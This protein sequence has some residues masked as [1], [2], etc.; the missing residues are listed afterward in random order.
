MD[1]L[2]DL[3][4]TAPASPRVNQPTPKAQRPKD[5]FSDLLSTTPKPVDTS[6]LSLLEHQQ[7]QQQR[8]QQSTNGSPWLTPTQATTPLSSTP[9]SSTPISTTPLTATPVSSGPRNA[10]ITQTSSFLEPKQSLTS[11]FE[12]LLNPFGSNT[13]RAEQGRNTPLNQL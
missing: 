13:K 2:L 10:H 5:A 8:Q 1:D 11:S 12:D 3:N 7:L 9:K 6:K 4:W